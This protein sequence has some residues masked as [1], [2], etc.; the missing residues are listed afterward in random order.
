MPGGDAAGIFT[1][2][3]LSSRE[4]NENFKLSGCC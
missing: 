1:L 4:D 3:G 2:V